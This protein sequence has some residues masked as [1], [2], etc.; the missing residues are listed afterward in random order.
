MISRLHL[1]SLF[2]LAIAVL[3]LVL[4]I[5]L[6]AM[7]SAVS[8]IDQA[9]VL[10]VNQV[11]AEG[12][13]LPNALFILTTATFTGDLDALNRDARQKLPNQQAIVIEVDTEH[14][15]LS[16]QAGTSV[17]LSDEQASYAVRDFKSE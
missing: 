14:R 17:N 2:L 3:V 8:I 6:N 10:N 16:V 15:N 5:P 1:R 12:A 9:H 7:A 13:K 11:R 4:L